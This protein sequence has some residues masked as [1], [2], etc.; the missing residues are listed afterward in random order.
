MHVT[1]AFFV[2]PT[3]T[4]FRF[5]LDFCPIFVQLRDKVIALFA[6]KLRTE[7]N[8]TNYEPKKYICIFN[9]M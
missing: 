9:N 4:Y 3:D 2:A 1:F 7:K 6:R 5:Y 8:R